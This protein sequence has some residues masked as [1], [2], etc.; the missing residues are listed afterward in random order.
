MEVAAWV[1]GGLFPKWKQPGGSVSTHL[2]RC[3]PVRPIR[4]GSSSSTHVMVHDTVGSV[5]ERAVVLGLMRHHS[6]SWAVL[7][8][9]ADPADRWHPWA[10]TV[11]RDEANARR[12]WRWVSELIARSAPLA[13]AALVGPC[14]SVPAR[15]VTPEHGAQ[16]VVARAFAAG[17]RQCDA[18][19]APAGGR[20][21][22]ARVYCTTC[23]PPTWPRRGEHWLFAGERLVVLGS[24]KRGGARVR[25]RPLHSALAREIP[26]SDWVGGAVRLPRLTLEAS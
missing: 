17:C 3:S 22:R 21:G 10:G 23:R 24:T 20:P 13:S 5:P 15:D 18:P 2:P 26:G 4:A 12:S 19:M 8:R 9:F 7:I 1:T 16:V 11:T 25:A 6:G 14:R